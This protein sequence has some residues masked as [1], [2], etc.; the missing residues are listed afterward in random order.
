IVG[1]AVAARGRL[2]VAHLAIGALGRPAV[3]C[4]ETCREI[5]G[6]AVDEYQ[7]VVGQERPA[8]AHHLAQRL[9][10][11][12]QGLRIHGVLRIR[13]RKAGGQPESADP[14][15]ARLE[16]HY[17]LLG[18]LTAALRTSVCYTVGWIGAEPTADD[19]DTVFRDLLARRRQPSS[20]PL[21]AWLTLPSHEIVDA[22]NL[23]HVFGGAPS[24]LD[25][26]SYHPRLVGVDFFWRVGAR[27]PTPDPALSD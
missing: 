19:D 9:P 22:S 1:M 18:P 14:V 15:L 7:V 13:L 21:Q 17:R 11:L 3:A 2:E 27:Q 26:R 16:L 5:V 4:L 24:E 6:I 8:R 20:V 12:L 10:V 23:R 25:G